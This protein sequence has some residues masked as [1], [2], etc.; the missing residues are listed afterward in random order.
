MPVIAHVFFCSSGFIIWD[1]AKFPHLLWP[2]SHIT[3]WWDSVRR[4][5]TEFSSNNKEM[6]RSQQ[7]NRCSTSDNKILLSFSDNK[8]PTSSTSRKRSDSHRTRF[9]EY[10]ANSIPNSSLRHYPPY[11][12]DFLM[13]TIINIYWLHLLIFNSL[14]HPLIFLN[15][16]FH[17]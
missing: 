1:W 6:V 2:M 16:Y 15:L 14:L 12:N 7:M 5:S 17:L 10:L 13:L 9:G 8:T 11:P 4:L 3:L